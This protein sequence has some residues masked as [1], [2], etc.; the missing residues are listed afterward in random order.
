MVKEK[1]KRER[2]FTLVEL[3]VVIVIL[4][5]IA[6]FILPKIS[7]RADEAKRRMAKLQIEKI[8]QQL[9]LF[10]FEVGR[11]PTTDEGLKVLVQNPGLENWKGPYLSPS[12]L[13]DPWGGDYVYRNPCTHSNVRHDYDILSYGP[14]K[15]EGGEGKNADITSWE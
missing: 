12:E 4:G 3:I 1:R 14:D 9:G 8:K 6:A 10:E 7:G 2:G 11:L 13:K 5:M 15:Q